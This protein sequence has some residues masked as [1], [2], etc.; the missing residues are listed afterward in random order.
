MGFSFFIQFY[1]ISRDSTQEWSRKEG[2]D[3]GRGG[4][5]ALV[6]GALT[7]RLPGKV[8]PSEVLFP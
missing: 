6:Y 5:C 7:S 4:A 3:L 1:E 2:K 8:S